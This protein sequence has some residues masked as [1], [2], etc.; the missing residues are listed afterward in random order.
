MVRKLK[1]F[2]AR[3]AKK[4]DLFTDAIQ[5]FMQYLKFKQNQVK[6]KIMAKVEKTPILRKVAEK[7]SDFKDN[8]N[9]LRTRL[10]YYAHKKKNKKNI[11]RAVDS[12]DDC[13]DFMSQPL[14]GFRTEINFNQTCSDN[15]CAT[16]LNTILESRQSGDEFASEAPPDCRIIQNQ[17]SEK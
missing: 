3:A 14:Y 8:L 1:T 10:K 7:V 9:C 11:K 16:N 17:C 2:F 13:F 15:V 12:M 6:A 5:D 4:Y